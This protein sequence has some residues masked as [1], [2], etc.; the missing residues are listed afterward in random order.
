[1]NP[2]MSVG[3]NQ[4]LKNGNVWRVEVEMPMQDSPDDAPNFLNI[5]VDVVSPNRDLAQYI[6]TT[7]YPDY[8]S[9]CIS[10]KP[11]GIAE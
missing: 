6:V 2:D 1:M 7:M 4:H 5:E 11:L 3:W 10:D 8:S 9:I